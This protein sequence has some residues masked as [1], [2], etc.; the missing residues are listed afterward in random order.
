MAGPFVLV[1]SI[2]RSVQ[3]TLGVAMDNATINQR[4]GA[5]VV[6]AGG[7]PV[8]TDAWAE[9]E[10]L[11][12]RVDAV[13]L[14]GGSDVAPELYGAERLEAT[15]AADPRRDDF[16][17]RLARAALEREVPVLGVCR[18]IQLLNVA[19][20]GSLLQDLG[21]DTTIEHYA[22]EE[23]DRPVHDVEIEPDSRLARVYGRR[24]S[25]NSVHH[26]AVNR[27]GEGL[28]VCARAAD[29]VIEGIEDER[30]LAIGVQWHPE[31]L[32]GPAGDEQVKLFREVLSA[33]SGSLV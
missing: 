17:L 18:G 14:N 21:G 9:P 12:E 1:T 5:L 24:T 28:R 2:P 32:A 27:V 30:G 10:A 7:V 26:Q 11:L 25:V 4:F 8:A 19:H 31:F 33:R 13:V 6:A 22:R 20:G 15:D 16:E 3:T 23:W 29:G